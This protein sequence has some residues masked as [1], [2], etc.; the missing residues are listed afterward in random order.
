MWVG[1][2]YPYFIGQKNKAQKD[3]IKRLYFQTFFLKGE[4]GRGRGRG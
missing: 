2:I 1:V 3:K 4:V